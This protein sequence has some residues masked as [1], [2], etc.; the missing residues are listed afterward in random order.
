MI[1]DDIIIVT[2]LT[3][4]SYTVSH[5]NGKQKHKLQPTKA[6][7]M[8]PNSHN[9]SIH[10][11]IV[12]HIYT[13]SVTPSYENCPDIVFFYRLLHSSSNQCWDILKDFPRWD[14]DLLCHL[15]CFKE[16]FNYGVLFEHFNM[17]TCIIYQYCDWLHTS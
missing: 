9:E 1:H 5:D 10:A 6:W 16:Q 13:P 15:Q 12:P 3:I 17:C 8:A 7:S 4:H 2:P 11:T 14:N